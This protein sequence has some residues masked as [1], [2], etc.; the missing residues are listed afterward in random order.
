MKVCGF[1]IVRNAIRFDYPVAES[2]RSL[3]PVV[4]EMLVLVGNSDD[5]TL[6]L[7]ESIGSP[8]IR[9][10]HSVWDDG[11]REGGRVLAV[12]TNK[13]LKSIA[14]EFDWC[15]YLQADE[16]LHEKWHALLRKAMEDNLHRT[17]VEGLL[18][19]YQ[20]FYGSY[21]YL[22]DSRTWYRREV[23]ILRNLP[24]MESY[25]D[26]QGFRFKGRKL[27]VLHSGAEIHHYGWVKNPRLQQEKQKNFH[28]LWHT[29]EQLGKF[30]EEAD[31]FDYNR[32][33]SLRIF[34]GSHPAV[35]QE[36]IRNCDWD[37]YFDIRHK[38]FGLKN[39]LLYHF[40]RLSGIRLFEY[41][42]YRLIR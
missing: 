28:K 35:M 1:T 22:G 10:L 19:D 14:P 11:L 27:Q 16:L 42:N 39:F 31:S 23:R 20:H 18:F 38:K 8:K 5:E 24:G 13:A 7:I 9:I 33:D 15:F 29:E 3:L 34:E 26:A 12:E 30:V 2:I 6:A 25:R 17:E 4:D 36:R 37:F 40:E 32:I 21:N 41:R